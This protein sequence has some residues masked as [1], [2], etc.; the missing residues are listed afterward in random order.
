MNLSDRIIAAEQR[1]FEEHLE[2]PNVIIMRPDI[3]TELQEEDGMSYF[4]D[5]DSYEGMTVAVTFDQT[6]PDF[7]VGVV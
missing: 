5:L 4:D 6:F 1:F 7:K 3:K 2:R